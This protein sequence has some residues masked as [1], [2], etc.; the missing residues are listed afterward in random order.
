M[1]HSSPLAWFRAAAP[2]INAHRGRTV[3][4]AFE[5]EALQDP[6][7]PALIHDIAMLHSLG[8]RL[9]LVHGARMQI[10]QQLRQTGQTLRYVNGLR[11]TDTQALSVVKAVV[12][13][14]RIDIEALLSQGLANTPMAGAQIEVIS[15]NHVI[16]RPLG[17]RNGVD[18]QHTGEVRR[19]D[20]TR[21]N[22]HLEQA[23]IVLLSPLG[24]S[25]T[26]EVFNLSSEE[27]ATTAAVAL[28]ADK[29]IFLSESGPLKDAHGALIGQLTVAQAQQLLHQ[30]EAGQCPLLQRQLSQ[31]VNACMHGIAR[32]HILNRRADGAVLLELYTHDGVGTLITAESFEQLRP[33]RIEDIG[34]ILELIGPLE[35]QGILVR[36]S[37]EQL[38][39]EIERFTVIE[40]DAK[41]LA[42]AALYPFASDG[43]AEL[44]CLAVHRDYRDGGRG[45]RLLEHLETQA[46]TQGI[47]RLFVLTTH[48]AHWFLERGFTADALDALPI[49]RRELYNWQR[50]SKIFSKTL[51]RPRR[52]HYQNETG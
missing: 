29:L 3:V 25:P 24:Y 35:S 26:G 45:D 48:T 9:V 44:A 10:E 41:I 38:E 32:V 51:N 11:V 39:L 46:Q 27:V 34:G 49:A 43:V 50:N 22:R 2:Y 47:S 52:R 8:V 5:G 6:R 42:C 4:I 12:G 30:C 37:R 16:A 36:R 19:I 1:P 23:Q 28:N 7:F 21:I 20:A 17:V 33:A 31:A 13:Q 14:L 15:G 40:R 18:Y